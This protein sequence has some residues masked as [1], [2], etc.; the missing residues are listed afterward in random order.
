MVGTKTKVNIIYK[1]DSP[2][3]AKREFHIGVE[4][5]ENQHKSFA[6]FPDEMIDGIVACE[7]FCDLELNED[8]TE[9]ISFIALELP[10]FMKEVSEPSAQDDTDAMLVD[11]EY[12]LTMLELGFV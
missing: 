2:F 10:D 9:V 6:I 8:G 4:W 12:R 5:D 11:L 3:L 7:A 1:L